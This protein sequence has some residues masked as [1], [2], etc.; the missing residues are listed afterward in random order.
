MKYRQIDAY[1]YRNVPARVQYKRLRDGHMRD[2]RALLPALVNRRAAE[3]KAAREMN[4]MLVR[5][6]RG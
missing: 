5:N 1:P 3:V 2:A 4:W 6:L